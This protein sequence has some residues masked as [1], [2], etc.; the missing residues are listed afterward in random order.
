MGRCKFSAVSSDRTKD[1]GHR[2]KYK[3]QRETEKENSCLGVSI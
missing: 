2:L 1:N 3:S